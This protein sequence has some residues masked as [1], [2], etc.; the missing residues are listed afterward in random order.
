[1]IAR[2][3]ISICSV[4]A[5]VGL[6]LYGMATSFVE[7]DDSMVNLSLILMIGGVIGT[8]IGMVMYRAAERSA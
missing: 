6:T 2:L 5:S 8:L 4:A 1:M 7:L 3:L